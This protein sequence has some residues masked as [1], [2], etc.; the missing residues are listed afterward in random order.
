MK[1]APSESFDSEGAC[2]LLKFLHKVR[3]PSISFLRS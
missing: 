3:I 2:W 1:R